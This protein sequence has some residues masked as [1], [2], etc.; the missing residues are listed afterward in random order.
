MHLYLGRHEFVKRDSTTASSSSSVLVTE[1]AQIG[2][3]PSIINIK[4][5]SSS[6]SSITTSGSPQDRRG[7]EVISEGPAT[8][9]NTFP[10]STPRSHA[11]STLTIKSTTAGTSGGSDIGLNGPTSTGSHIIGSQKSD[12][13]SH[14]TEIVST[15][16]SQSSSSITSSSSRSTHVTRETF[17]AIPSSSST[18]TSAFSVITIYSSSATPGLD[19]LSVTPTSH[20]PIIN[21]IPTS[22]DSAMN[23]SSPSPSLTSQHHPISKLPAI[24]GGVIGGLAGLLL[25]IAALYLYIHHRRT[26]VQV[27]VEERWEVFGKP[28]SQARERETAN[29]IPIQTP[30]PKTPLPVISSTSQFEYFN[31]RSF[32]FPFSSTTTTTGPKTLQPTT[33]PSSV[34]TQFS[35]NVSTRLMIN[36]TSGISTQ[37]LQNGR[38][39]IDS[40]RNSPGGMPVG[41]DDPFADPYVVLRARPRGL[42]TPSPTIRPYR[43]FDDDDG[44]FGDDGQGGAVLGHDSDGMELELERGPRRKPYDSSRALLTP[45]LNR[46]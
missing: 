3:T 13:T 18:S 5:G 43:D 21:I 1:L 38:F 37:I 9:T 14:S 22:N 35:S 39:V 10:T 19:T 30:P 27:Q 4:S 11:S 12:L 15:T 46:F 36:T 20:G 45:T 41:D 25:I 8:S 40:P 31:S 33:S 2:P 16:T 44:P 29:I 34:M 28:K 32:P 42:C 24:I 23:E 6:S 7:D 17:K 26:Q